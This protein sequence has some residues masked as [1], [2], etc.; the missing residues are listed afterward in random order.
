MVVLQVALDLTELVRAASLAAEIASVT[1]CGNV[2]IEA[3]TPLIKSWGRVAVK[4]LKDLTGCFVIADTKTMDVPSVEGSMM[5]EAGAD[6]FTVLAVADD[7]T[8]KEA[9]E[10][11]RSYGRAVIGDLISHP[12]PLQ[13][14]I[15]LYGLGVDAVT[16]H[17]GISVQKARGL[18][19]TDLLDEVDRIKRETPLRVAVAGGIRPGDVRELTRRGVDVIVI[20]SAVTNAVKPVDV[21]TK[22]LDDMRP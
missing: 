16:Y 10:T 11:A 19:V 4:A 9:G 18:R 15:E 7:E 17:I 22:V 13:R 8:I 2:W 3:G 5:Y 1:K 20:G 6:A 14:A 12:K 21:V